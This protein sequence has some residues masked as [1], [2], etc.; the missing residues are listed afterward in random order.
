M[1]RASSLESRSLARASWRW[2]R[3][4]LPLLVVTSTTHAHSPYLLPNAF[5]VVERKHVTVEASFT[6]TFFVP[7]V[8][9]KADDYHVL[10]PSG[11]KQPL[12]PVYTKDLAVIEAPTLE[13]GTYRIST[14]QRSGRTSKAIYREG[15]WEFIEP[16]KP[17]PAGERVY[18]VKSI[19][20]ADVF[21]SRGKPDNA[22]L[23]PRNKG[24]EFRPISHP[25]SLF[26]GKEAK[27]EV[28]FDGR[29]LANH[30]VSVHADDERYS[31]RKIYAETKTDGAGLFSVK[32]DRPG[33]YLAMTRH[34]LLP[35]SNGE[36][37]TSHT[38]SVTFE[39]TE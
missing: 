3:L 9:M 35:A 6:E 37:A 27:F 10:T 2:A 4:V 15:D 32:L 13:Q 20:T 29:P 38:Y 14:G 36:P 1:S 5:D 19:T 18:D 28:L 24:L 17:V 7:D 16:G 23:V 22:A 34:R 8:A 25:N 26:V 12:T 39:A 30:A 31:S 21:V 33:I 11:V